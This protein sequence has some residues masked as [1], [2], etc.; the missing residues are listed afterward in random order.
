[1]VDYVAEANEVNYSGV[2]IT[3]GELTSAGGKVPTAIKNVS[4]K[5]GNL[6]ADSTLKTV[7]YGSNGKA[8]VQV[9]LKDIQRTSVA[10]PGT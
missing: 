2:T 9:Y 4:G 3:E 8:Y 1:M 10:Y 6:G 5:S 7:S